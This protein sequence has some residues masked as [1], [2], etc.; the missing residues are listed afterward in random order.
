MTIEVVDHSRSSS[1]RSVRSDTVAKRRKASVARSASAS[2]RQNRNANGAPDGPQSEQPRMQQLNQH[3]TYHE[4]PNAQVIQQAAAEVM[5]PQACEHHV[6]FEASKAVAAS[7]VQAAQDVASVHAQATSAVAG[8]H[9]QAVQ[10][11]AQLRA[12]YG[13]RER[14]LL[15]TIKSLQSQLAASSGMS[16]NGADLETRVKNQEHGSENRVSV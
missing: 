12:E 3:L 15:Q 2:V 14:E 11:L 1:A 13:K 7:Q 10:H 5:R 4:A 16:P 9:A 6:H 8:I